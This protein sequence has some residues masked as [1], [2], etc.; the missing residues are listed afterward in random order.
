MREDTKKWQEGLERRKTVLTAGV[1]YQEGLWLNCCID[2]MMVNL[3]E[4][5]WRSWKGA[6]KNGRVENSSGERILKGR[7]MS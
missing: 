1:S 3:R 6:R 7:V 4:S 2:G 5:I